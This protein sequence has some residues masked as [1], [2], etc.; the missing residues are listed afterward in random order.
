MAEN[1][2]TTAKRPVEYIK[3]EIDQAFHKDSIGIDLLLFR[4]PQ[5]E[6]CVTESSRSIT[7]GS[8][9]LW[10]LLLS[11]LPLPLML[12]HDGGVYNL[13]RTRTKK[14]NQKITCFCRECRAV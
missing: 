10:S 14:Q 2:L 8:L 13:C 9:S 5:F 7:F 3:C 1:G 4:Q 12:Q 6:M 11:R